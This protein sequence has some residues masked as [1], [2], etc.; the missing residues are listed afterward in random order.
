MFRVDSP[1]GEKRTDY[2][3]EMIEIIFP[4]QE[5]D[6]CVLGIALR[7]AEC[8]FSSIQVYQRS[9]VEFHCRVHNTLVQLQLQVR[10]TLAVT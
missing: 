2:I 6:L 5:P 1:V 8:T 10:F 7:S 4:V 3:S 9:K